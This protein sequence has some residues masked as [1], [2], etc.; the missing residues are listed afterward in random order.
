MKIKTYLSTQALVLSFFVP[1]MV[2]QGRLTRC[3]WLRAM[4]CSFRLDAMLTRGKGVEGKRYGNWGS[5]LYKL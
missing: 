5:T 1:G 2:L 3:S 4:L